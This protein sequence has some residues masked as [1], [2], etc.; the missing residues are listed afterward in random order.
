[1]YI[2]CCRRGDKDTYRV[3]SDQMR[4]IEQRVLRKQKVKRLSTDHC[5]IFCTTYALDWWSGRI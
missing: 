5:L 3:Y 2:V 1:M 4:P